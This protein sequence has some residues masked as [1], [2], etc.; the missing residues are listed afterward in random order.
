[1]NSQDLFIIAEIGVN[2]NGS[3]DMA[4]KMVD[5]AKSCGVSAVKFQ[6]LSAGK[7]IAE[8]SFSNP[9]DFGFD[10]VRTLSDFWE[11]VSIDKSFQEK[12]T[13]YCRK[14]D[15]EFMSTPFD[16]ENADIL[17]ELGVS[18]FKI[19][20][21]DITHFPMLEF[22][23][24]KGKPIILSTGAATL[25]EIDEA[26]HFI[27]Q[28]GEI[29]LT[30]LHCVSLYP[31]PPELANLNAIT[32]LKSV[33]RLPVGYSDHTIG[34]HLPLAAIAKGAVVIE[35]H[36]TLDKNLPGP[37]HK[38]SA[39]PDDLRRIVEFGNQIRASLSEAYK[40]IS[41]EEEAMRIPIRRSIVADRELLRGTPLTLADLGFK[42]PGDGVSAKH[43]REFI[44]KK[45]RKDIQK[46]LSITWGM[47]DD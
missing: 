23:A 24:Q 9:V 42:R 12:I 33:F 3:L 44:G 26:I 43:Y 27:R 17:D 46:D 11:K 31:T 41:R 6:S 38:Q 35:K 16:F 18:R 37:D 32:Q 4:Q 14:A 19:A 40:M 29:D 20:S 13:D 15:I 10:D 1:M 7:L 47:L 22:V 45:L 28:H 39:D 36:F 34:Y 5:A 21:G 30:L 25:G 2:H 8:S